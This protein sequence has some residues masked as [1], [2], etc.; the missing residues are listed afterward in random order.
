MSGATC[1]KCGAPRAEGT[2]PADA[3]SSFYEC[4]T[5]V[6]RRCFEQSWACKELCQ[7][8][9]Q[10]KVSG[11]EPLNIKD[12]VWRKHKRSKNMMVAST[13]LGDRAVVGRNID[14]QWWYIV[15]SYMKQ[16]GETM[17]A[18]KDACN[19]EHKRLIGEWVVG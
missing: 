2:Q 10:L 16:T 3:S 15:G 17:E 8:R 9:E 12:L 18:C 6:E 5:V 4:G 11:A 7:L 13:A 14:G 1:P 19:A